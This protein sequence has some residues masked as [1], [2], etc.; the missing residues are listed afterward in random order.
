MDIN[1]ILVNLYGLVKLKLNFLRK[2]KKKS[3]KLEWTKFNEGDL[4]AIFHF[5]L[6]LLFF[7][8]NTNFRFLI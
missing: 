4:L 1:S 5:N 8:T 7:S 6:E 2:L 3:K